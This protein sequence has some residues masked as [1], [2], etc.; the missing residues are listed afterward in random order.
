[1]HES[2]E[3]VDLQNFFEDD[4]NSVQYVNDQQDANFSIDKSAAKQRVIKRQSQINLNEGST[5]L[6]LS[7]NKNV[8]LPQ[9]SFGPLS[10]SKK[11]PSQSYNSK[12][13]ILREQL[14]NAN[15]Q[16]QVG[17]RESQVTLRS[18]QQQNSNI[19]SSKSSQRF[20]Q[21]FGFQNSVRRRVSKVRPSQSTFF[22][23]KARQQVPLHFVQ[24]T[25]PIM[26]LRSVRKIIARNAKSLRVSDKN[27]QMIEITKRDLTSHIYNR[28][29]GLSL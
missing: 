8:R 6:D 1:M 4:N 10:I 19:D 21:S 16:T 29:L 5:S 3:A 23:L 28:Y 25:D 12:S 26:I 18:K 14:K 24:F 17:R 20:P 13:R 11:D 2:Q 27:Y 22:Q 7:F 15:I 9:I